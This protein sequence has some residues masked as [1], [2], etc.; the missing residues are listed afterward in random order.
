M[1]EDTLPSRS[2]NEESTEIVPQKVEPEINAPA[3]LDSFFQRK[4]IKATI[5]TAME[6]WLL[7]DP[8]SFIKHV[9]IPVARARGFP[10][11]KHV[12][13]VAIQVVSAVPRPRVAVEG[14]RVVINDS[15]DEPC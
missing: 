10:Q 4:D 5:H 1:P 15:E 11:A 2:K 14:H 3:I 13:D 8:R 12:A 7:E 9:L 6:D